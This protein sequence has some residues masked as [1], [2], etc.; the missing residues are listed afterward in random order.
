GVTLSSDDRR[1]LRAGVRCQR[2]VVQAIGRF[3]RDRVLSAARGMGGRAADARAQRNLRRLWMH[4]SITIDTLRGESF[5]RLGAPCDVPAQAGTEVD[6][7]ALAS[8]TRTAIGT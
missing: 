1:T 8:C 4:C 3:A 5:P 7:T 2:A 6:P